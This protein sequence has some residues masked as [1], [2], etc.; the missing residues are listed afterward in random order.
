MNIPAIRRCLFFGERMGRMP[1]GVEEARYGGD[2]TWRFP[3]WGWRWETLHSMLDCPEQIQTSPTSMFSSLISLF[4][5][6]VRV[7][8]LARLQFVELD[9]PS[10]F[11]NGR[12][13]SFTR[14]RE[15]VT[16]SP[17]SAQPQIG[18]GM[19]RCRTMFEFKTLGNLTSALED[20]HAQNKAR[21]TRVIFFMNLG[22]IGE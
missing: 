22:V 21:E 10:V 5:L 6:T 18:T 19:S 1:G 4:P 15:T 17:L 12:R 2:W 20:R 8:G 13:F 11:A 9:H 3:P 16:F 14:Q 7:A